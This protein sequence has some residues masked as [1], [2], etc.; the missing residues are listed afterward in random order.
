MRNNPRLVYK[1]IIERIRH[2]IKKDQLWKLT[3]LTMWRLEFP[4]EATR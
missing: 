2:A 1:G 3:E 4:I